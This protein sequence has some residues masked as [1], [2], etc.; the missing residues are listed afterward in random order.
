MVVKVL[1]LVLRSTLK[2]SSVDELSSQL[3]VSCAAETGTAEIAVAIKLATARP[4]MRRG[5]LRRILF[6]RREA[7]VKRVI[8]ERKNKCIVREICHEDDRQTES[9]FELKIKMEHFLLRATDERKTAVFVR[10]F[11]TRTPVSPHLNPVSSV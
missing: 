10:M 7:K 3:T 9:Y 4:R 5:I 11:F 6:R 8:G 2:P 1:P